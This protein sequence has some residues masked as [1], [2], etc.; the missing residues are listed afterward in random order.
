MLG[1]VRALIEQLDADE[2]RDMALE[3][4]IEPM[5]SVERTREELMRAC[6]RPFERQRSPFD[7]GRR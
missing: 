6:G 2:R 1:I 3:L 7:S 5:L 4:G